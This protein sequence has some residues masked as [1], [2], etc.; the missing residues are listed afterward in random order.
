LAEA[1][2]N[3]IEEVAGAGEHEVAANTNDAGQRS[4]V[5]AE[6]RRDSGPKPVAQ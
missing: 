2:A 1:V 5:G 3:G 4:Q 6:S